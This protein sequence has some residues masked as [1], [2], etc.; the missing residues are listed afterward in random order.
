[1]TE[2]KTLDFP[3]EL[4]KELTEEGTFEGYGSV[5]DVLDSDTEV[6]DPGAFTETLV[7]RAG[8]IK[9]LWQHS[10][11]DPIGVWLELLEDARGLLV[12]GKLAIKASF[13]RD[14]YELLKIGA[15]DGLSIGFRTIKAVMDE[16][17]RV[18]H[19]VELELWEVSLVTFPANAQA[20]VAAV[21][22]EAF[23]LTLAGMAGDVETE[24][25]FEGF[26]RDA[27]FSNSR[28]KAITAVGFRNAG[29]DGAASELSQALSRATE[30]IRGVS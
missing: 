3:F 27:G 23:R 30:N 10:S 13:P 2:M 21:K 28:S 26:L 7:K 22:D 12:K 5:F 20:T 15:L 18:R 19:L 14:V 16:D 17:D 25:Q 1:M 24:R 11:H 4:T 8:K 9:L 29:R 6:V